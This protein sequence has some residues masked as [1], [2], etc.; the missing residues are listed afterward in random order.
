MKYRILTICVLTL[1]AGAGGW[2]FYPRAQ[3]RVAY[4]TAEV[5]RGQLTQTIRAT[6]TIE[7][8]DLIDIGAQVT[9]QIMAFGKDVQG[10]EVD[11]CSEVKKGQ[12]LARID[13]VTYRAE[14]TIAQA[15]LATANANLERAQAD[16]VQYEAKRLQAERD[17]GRA[18]R[19]GVGDALSQKEY[20]AYLSAHDVAKANLAV[21]KAA[22][23]QAQ[24]SISQAQ[25]QLDKAQ[26]NLSY[27][28]ILA[29]VDGIVIDRRVNIGQTVTASMSTPSLFLV[30]KDLRKIQIWVPVNEADIGAIQLGQNVRFTVDAFAGKSFEGQVSRIRLNASMSSNV[31][32]YTVEV[33]TENPTGL[34]L[35]YLTANVSF[36][37]AETPPEALLVPVA[38]LRWQPENQSS[39][40]PQVFVLNE[41]GEPEA[42]PVTIG[43]SD[44]IHTSI[45]S[46]SLEKGDPVIVGT[47]TA[48]EVARAKQKG[49]NPFL[50][51]MPGRRRHGNLRIGG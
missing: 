24:A 22:I 8:E 13:D 40:T 27:C 3:T 17:Y 44:D 48:T 41:K 5:I 21:G 34:L 25:A 43:V 15:A 49:G 35:P 18:Q 12:L 29:T 26:R 28:D 32:T 20:D 14:V 2:F 50:P 16:E 10:N 51:K 1:A 47:L 19:L 45:S 39:E 4:K 23:A 11:Y 6:G 46:T 30:A 37:L 9:G 33:S 42:V 7:P 36:I 38:A 31:V